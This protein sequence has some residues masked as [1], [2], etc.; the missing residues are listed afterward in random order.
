MFEN[1]LWRRVLDTPEIPLVSSRKLL[2]RPGFSLYVTIVKK[3]PG[4]KESPNAPRRLKQANQ[5]STAGNSATAGRPRRQPI[6]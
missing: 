4:E 2:K 5:K 1:A 6:A 3:R